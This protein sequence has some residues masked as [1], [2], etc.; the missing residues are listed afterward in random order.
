M[1]LGR[2]RP[3]LRRLAESERA[4]KRV[5][6][7]PRWVK[8]IASDIAYGPA[9]PRQW[10]RTVM[11]QDLSRLFEELQR[12]PLDVVEVSGALRESNRW[13]SYTQLHYPEFDLCD[14]GPVPGQFDLVIC[15]QVLEHVTDPER[16]VRTLKTLCRPHGHVVVSTPFLIRVHEDPGDYWRFTADGLRLLLERGGLSPVWVR[17]W[18]NRKAL[19]ANLGG[20]ARQLPWRSLR[21][22]PDVPL[23]VW[24]LARV[25]AQAATEDGPR[26]SR[27]GAQG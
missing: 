7:S 11:D 13:G 20:W 8:E 17:S 21:N 12:E 10:V 5:A 9:Q 3:I 23:V 15:E 14:P 18:G 6:G 1:A 4:R 2:L 22:E 24:A 27:R 25:T 19:R 26:A 16:A